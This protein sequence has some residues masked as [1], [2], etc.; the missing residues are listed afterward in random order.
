VSEGSA[1]ITVSTV[2]GNK[3]ASCSVT[4]STAAVAVT[5]VSLNKTTMVIDTGSTE[6][7]SVS[8]EPS[9]ATNQNVSWSSSNEDIATVS[10]NGTVTGLAEGSAVITA[11]TEDGNKTAACSVSVITPVAVTGVSLNKDALELNIGTSE[12]LSANIS[13]ANA[14]N[15]NITW[16]SS[17]ASVATVSESG[18]VSGITAGEAV[19]TVTTEDGSFSAIC[20]VSVTAVAVTGV[21]LNK[22]STSI[23]I[24]AFETLT[25]TI[26]PFNATN[27]NV[28]WSSS[29]SSV[30]S[31]SSSGVVYGAS[32]GSATI[33]V[34]TVDGNKT[35]TCSVTVSAVN[36]TPV[37]ADFTITGLGTFPASGAFYAVLIQ[38][39][40]GKSPGLITVYYNGSVTAPSAAGNYVV[41]FD[42]AAAQGWNAASGL[43][44]GTL[45][46]TSGSTTVSVTDVTLNKSSTNITVGDTETLSA[47]IIPSNATNKAVTWSSSDASVATVSA[48]GVVTGKLGGSATITVTTADG[49]KTANCTVTVNAGAGTTADPFIVHDAETLQRVGKGTGAW[50]GDWSMS[51]SYIQTANIDLSSVTNWTPIG[52]SSDFTG[53]YDGDG[54]TINNLTINNPTADRQG[55]FGS[56]SGSS[57]IVKNIGLVNC[58]ITGKGSVGGVVGIQSYSTVQNCYVTGTVS[59]ISGVGGVAGESSTGTVQNSHSM[60]TVSGT[61]QVGGVVGINGSG[62]TVENCYSTGNVS[63]TGVNGNVGGVAGSQSGGTVKNCYSTGAVS[64]GGGSVGGVVGSSMLFSLWGTSGT[65]ENCYSTGNVSGTSGVGGVLGG[66]TSSYLRNCYSTG[67]VSGTTNVGGVVGGN[68]MIQDKGICRVENCYATGNV[69]GTGDYV[70]GVAGSRYYANVKNCAAL[71]PNISGTSSILGRVA[72]DGDVNINNIYGREDMNKDGSAATW[73]NNPSGDKDGADVTAADW[74]SESWWTGTAGFSASVWDFSG[75]SATKGPSL[76][77]MQGG[78]QNPVIQ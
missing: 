7:L 53:S 67:D 54:Y 48:G 3:T 10:M 17:D 21:T 2:D 8:F 38:A 9:N 47:N 50:T 1:V 24:G 32:A 59:G 76:S 70:G 11:S 37:A 31:V 66:N 64:G 23:T 4:V 34:T 16:S 44:A 60:G 43:P 36:Q 68:S 29:N 19:I 26:A 14:T 12:T 71:N 39:K 51:A 69:S 42:V 40:A 58:S 74:S 27:R 52:S 72:G 45:V 35:A 65:V 28:S 13:P 30:A 33:T 15:Q 49:N 61:Q 18:L 63:G 56:L 62:G 75:I 73:A 46:I 5:G 41:T 77:G 57:T 20:A 55:L 25:A 78:P 6:T 22:S